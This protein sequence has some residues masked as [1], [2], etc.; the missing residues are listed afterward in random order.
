[1]L[2]ALGVVYGDIGTSPLY[3]LQ[4]VFAVDHGAVHATRAGVL[5]V[6]S[7]LFWTITL[8]VPVKYVSFVMR[9]DNQGEGGVL[10][11]GA[12]GRKSLGRGRGKAALTVIVIGVLGA[13][14]F[15]GDS[16]ITPAISVLSAVEGLR[17]STP[18]LAHMVV[19]LAATIL[20][21]LFLVQRWGTHRVGS[22]FGPVMMVWFGAI[23]LAGLREVTAQPG[24]VAG[25]SPWYA[26]L[27]VADH[28]AIAFVAL[29]AVVLAVTGAEALY[30]DMGHFGRAPIR[31]S[32]FVIVFPALT[33][34]YLGQAGL[35]LRDPASKT[36]PFFLLLPGWSRLAMVAL[37][38][39][40]TVIASQAVISG[41][42]SVARQAVQLGFLP[43]LHIRHTS[44]HEAGQV[45]VPSVNWVLFSGVLALVL[46][47]RSSEHLAAAYGV[48]VTGT[49]V[50][51]TSLFLVV[52]RARWHWRRLKLVVAGLV[53]GGIELTLFASNLTKVPHGAW[54][55]L[56][57]AAFVFTMMT[58]WA[59][60]AEIVTSRR[61]VMEGSLDQF[62]AELRRDNVVRVPGTA[63][64]PHRSTRSV[65]LAL[66]ANLEHNH[67]VHQRVVIICAV[68]EDVPTVPA[69]ERLR[70]D[71]TDYLPDGVVRVSARYGFKEDQD[72]AGVLGAA[73]LPELNWQ[74]DHEDHNDLSYFVSRITLRVTNAPGMSRWRKKFF[75][76]M[77]HNSSSPADFFCLPEVQTVIM[78]SQV[79]I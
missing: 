29:G 60:G 38:T 69:V 63:V 8:V 41:G 61:T 53:F 49:F 76:A 21:L 44:S 19:P 5:S 27:F 65:P 68:S 37:A 2:G 50:I 12:L 11:L 40:A 57:V 51:T 14:L 66:R 67:V 7:M 13:S 28:P 74:S 62:I 42:F 26:A 58:T 73:G 17:V 36:D 25:L 23:G 64:L 77:A 75:V 4:A 9:A 1:M 34:N 56:L 59:R 52:A 71:E 72:I 45:Y 24:V 16:V 46:A 47:F 70:I 6:I 32:W 54:V 48:A 31:Q 43:Y 22:L 35:L 18:A 15:Y 30:A 33:L 55:P 39:A 79:D 78:G 20:C 10:A 3:A